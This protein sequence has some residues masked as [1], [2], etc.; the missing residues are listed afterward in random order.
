MAQIDEGNAFPTETI[1]PLDQ[2][3]PLFNTPESPPE[4]EM[5]S[6]FTETVPAAAPPAKEEDWS[7]FWERHRHSINIRKYQQILNQKIT[8]Y[9]KDKKPS[10]RALEYFKGDLTGEI[11]RA[12]DKEQGQN[13]YDMVVN[14]PHMHAYRELAGQAVKEAIDPKLQS[15]TPT[16]F[17][18]WWDEQKQLKERGTWAKVGAFAG[19]AVKGGVDVTTTLGKAG[20]EVF[21]FSPLQAEWWKSTTEG[22]ARGNADFGN[23]IANVVQSQGKNIYDED[24]AREL[25][26]LYLDNNFFQNRRDQ[27]FLF[28]P[29]DAQYGSIFNQYSPEGSTF[30]NDAGELVFGPMTEATSLIADPMIFTGLPVARVAKPVVRAGVKTGIMIVGKGAGGVRQLADKTSDALARRRTDNV[31]L[32]KLDTAAGA[33]EKT[34]GL[35]GHTSKNVETVAKVFSTPSGQKRFLSRLLE[36]KAL[37]S[38]SLR[39][40]AFL[41]YKNA[42]TEYGDIAFNM[43]VDGASVA[44]V[45]SALA[46]ASGGGPEAMGQAAGAGGALGGMFGAISPERGAGKSVEALDDKGRLGPRTQ[47]MR[48]QTDIAE[49]GKATFDAIGQTAQDATMAGLTSSEKTDTDFM[50]P[51][52]VTTYL[53]NKFG[54]QAKAQFDALP[55]ASQALYLTMASAFGGSTPKFHIFQDGAEMARF[56]TEAHGRQ[57]NPSNMAQGMYDR[58]SGVIFLH[59]GS[60]INAVITRAFA[61][62]MGH[63]VIGTMLDAALDDARSP[64]TPERRLYND[65]LRAIQP[66][67]GETVREFY[68]YNDNVL[69]GTDLPSRKVD[70]DLSLIHI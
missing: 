10:P 55:A 34:A 41:A 51:S 29:E 28:S 44:G 53:R 30:R 65:I 35:V 9:Q 48:D 1:D 18:Y 25:Y 33:V 16:S 56:L 60:N 17:E 62:E 67:E 49:V 58:D 47:T 19:G 31:V 6:P 59:K 70:S 8:N 24:D 50:A 38:P 46:Y 23:M 21:F 26:Q 7:T 11:F 37:D 68:E 3:F 13:E 57:Y 64:G 63:S 14:H 5:G 20:A 54:S 4:G 43:L 40:L 69:T 32:K 52:E 39:N 45:M 15:R 12:P 61:H 42:G 36:D 66:K 27:G 2:I 22:V